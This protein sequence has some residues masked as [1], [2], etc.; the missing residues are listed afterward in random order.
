[1]EPSG[2]FRLTSCRLVSGWQQP[3]LGDESTR[4]LSDACAFY[5]PSNCHQRTLMT[6]KKDKVG[7][8]RRINHLIKSVRDS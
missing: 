1:M 6:T 8:T 5:L 2:R 3:M 4:I 7:Q